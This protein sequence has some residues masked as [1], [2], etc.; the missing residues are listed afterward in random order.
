M[1]GLSLSP[2]LPPALLLPPLLALAALACLL[3][4]RQA[5]C[6][7]ATLRATLLGLRLAAL[8]LLALWLLRPIRWTDTPR[9]DGSRIAVLADATASMGLRRDCRDA[10]GHPVTRWE[11]LLAQ[12]ATAPQSTPLLL[13]RVGTR[14][15]PAL[16]WEE[17]ASFTPLAGQTDLGA[18]LEALEKESRR[19]GALP[20]R[21]VLLISDGRDWGG[22]LLAQAKSLAE[23]GLPV[24][25]LALGEATPCGDVKVEFDPRTPTT[26]PVGEEGTAYL[27]L[28]STLP[29]PQRVTVHLRELHGGASTQAE[30]VVPPGGEALCPLPLP[31]AQTPGERLYLAEIPP[32]P[33]DEQPANNTA[34]QVVEYQPP[35][36][37]QV[38]Y[39]G[40]TPDWEWRFLRKALAGSP[41]LALQAAILLLP[42]EKKGEGL[43]PSWRPQRPFFSL[44]KTPR[45]DFPSTEAEYA[46]V[47]VV[48]LPC[49]AAAALT[50]PQ[51]EALLSFVQNRGGGILW[52]GDASRLPATLAPLLPGKDFQECRSNGTAQVEAAPERMVF[53]GLFL[54]PEPLPPDTLFTR[55]RQPRPTARPILQDDTATPLL[56]VEGN[57]GAGR[58]AW[59]GL[60]ESWRWAFAAPPKTTPS[61]HRNY[62]RQL[63]GWLGGNR[64]PQLELELPETGLLA[65]E[66]NRI[67]LR[68]LG[69]DFRPALEAQATL[70]A[71]P[72]DKQGQEFIPL[73]PDPHEPGRFAGA[74]TPGN[75]APVQFVATVRCTP[76]SPPLTLK[77]S[78]P[79]QAAGQEAEELAAQP[80]LLRDVARITGGRVFQGQVDWERLPLSG[81]IP[82]H[83]Q[84]APL[85]PPA[86]PLLCA[87]ACL[88]AEYTLRRKNGQP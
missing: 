87:V 83:R 22:R 16:P 58:A 79:V 11:A 70:A 62:W 59:S 20:L 51:Q 41:S 14:E 48:V 80:E 60:T 21:A 19:P 53:E 82:R 44:G 10:A 40:T 66:E 28:A 84:E 37:R 8:A 72:L 30:A 47:D 74:Y 42:P 52:T 45:E 67:A 7:P 38:L 76:D 13:W 9:E 78:L 73:A 39:L 85:L 68:V 4:R 65:H 77:K 56:L 32:L 1:E 2:L 50:T 23:M 31:A 61:L 88:L 29:H 57:C 64:Q 71:I 81:N 18:A 17:G 15:H 69:P 35:P 86:L 63:L 3:A 55:C 26:L 75:T 49:Q 36:V 25:T 27:R 12:V 24:S 33:G 43:S 46:G 5:K 6:L 34:C 54:Q